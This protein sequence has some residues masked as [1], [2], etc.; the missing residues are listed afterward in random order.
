MVRT[1]RFWPLL[2]AVAA[3]SCR[4]DDPPEASTTV[5]AF[6]AAT[7]G[8]PIAASSP[9]SASEAW[10]LAFV[11]VETTGLVAGWHEMIDLGIVMTDLDG[12]TLD[13]LFV[14]VQ[15][16][17]PERTADGA[18]AVNAFDA[19]RWRELGA[20]DPA[21][22]V[23][24]LRAFHRR[25]AGD[26]PVLLVAFNSQFDTAFLDHLFRGVGASWRE[27]FHYFVLDIPSMAWARGYRDLTG[28]ALAER[29]GVED[30]P[31][32]AEEHTGITGAR[33]N[34]RLYRALRAHGMDAPVGATAAGT[35]ATR[36]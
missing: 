13:S 11:D 15:P 24:T 5:P 18:R 9:A 36:D 1:I 23:D 29:L 4:P 25:V 6:V 16:A 12:G 14:R 20:L 10:R 17:H 27:L 32:V 22:A 35:S 26:G 34:A 8:A 28:A 30:E 19:D 3:S 33:L 31:H 2:I 21:A 7:E